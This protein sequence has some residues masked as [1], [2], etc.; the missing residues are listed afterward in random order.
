MVD[1]KGR[2]DQS[3]RTKL[4]CIGNFVRRERNSHGNGINE[5]PKR[6]DLMRRSRVGFLLIEDKTERRKGGHDVT[7]IFL[8]FKERRC[9]SEPIINIC[10][11]NDALSSKKSQNGLQ[12][13]GKF[14]WGAADAK[15]QN[16]VH[17]HTSLPLKFQKFY[18]MTRNSYGK[19]GISKIKNGHPAAKSDSR[20]NEIESFHLKMMVLD[21]LVERM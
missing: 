14:M 20:N 17:K 4:D 16:N 9:T 12:D 11:N 15:W 1:G 6:S 21:E 7:N 13:L 10:E 19:V 2:H 5:E 8:T 18:V 3:C